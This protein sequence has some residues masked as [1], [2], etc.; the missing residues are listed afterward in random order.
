MASLDKPATPITPTVDKDGTPTVCNCCGRRAIGVGIGNPLK[1]DPRYLCPQCLL[2][3]EKI[4]SIKRLDIYETQA[5]NGGVDAIGDWIDANGGV[6]DLAYY[7][8][9]MQ[10]QL[11]RA[12]WIGCTDRLRK[13]L[14]DGCAPF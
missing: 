10:L 14:E 9:L 12:C 11:V 7:D 6:T 13:L 4:K 2:I 5:I 3:V 8:E 1:E